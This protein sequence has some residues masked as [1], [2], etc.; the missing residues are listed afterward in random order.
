METKLFV[1]PK[2]PIGELGV[3][4]ALVSVGCTCSKVLAQF[5]KANDDENLAICPKC[6]RKYRLVVEEVKD[7]TKR[8]G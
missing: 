8:T 5:Q 7:A 3:I 6:G 2:E 1:T 4:V